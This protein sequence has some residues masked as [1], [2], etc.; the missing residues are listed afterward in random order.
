MRA[1]PNLCTGMPDNNL[2][3]QPVQTAQERLAFIHFQWEVY[4]D[5]PYWVPPL[6]SERVEFLD[7]ERH[8]FYQHSEVQLFMARRD[9]QPVGTLVTS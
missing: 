7:Q 4:K 5:D 2:T 1:L 9:G 8:P 6:I 3:I